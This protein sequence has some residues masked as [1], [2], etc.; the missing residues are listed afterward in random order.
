MEQFLAFFGQCSSTCTISHA[1]TTITLAY[2]DEGFA[3]KIVP[4]FQNWVVRESERAADLTVLLVRRKDIE[5]LDTIFG[6]GI[7]LYSG[8]PQETLVSSQNGMQFVLQRSSEALS[9]IQLEQ[10]CA[11]YVVES[12]DALS[13]T[14]RGSPLKHILSAFFCE[15]DFLVLHAAAVAYRG[16]TVLISGSSGAGKSTLSAACTQSGW[17]FLSDDTTLCSRDGTVFGVYNTLKLQAQQSSQFPFLARCEKLEG[18]S[19]EKSVY[20][21]NDESTN[22]SDIS[23]ASALVFPVLSPGH[24]SE[25]EPISKGEAYR[26]LLATSLFF[27]PATQSATTV[28]RL[29]KLARELPA[30]RLVVG[31]DPMQVPAVIASVLE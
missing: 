18:D 23:L 7:K 26:R 12:A 5:E 15:K 27:L 25:I 2:A 31:E 19:T 21:M 1:G 24:A 10:R 11:A 9:V 30:Y 22:G 28:N 4:A 17:S 13:N 6:E 8:H 14:E 3:S 16:S 20:F 29:A